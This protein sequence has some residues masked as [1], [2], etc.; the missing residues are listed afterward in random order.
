[1]MTGRIVVGL[2]GSAN[3]SAAARWALREA[4]LRGARLEAVTAFGLFAPVG[5]PDRG[6]LQT[7]RELADACARMQHEQLV[8]L[9]ADDVTVMTRTAPGDAAETLVATAAGA[10]MLV[11]GARGRGGLTGLM[12]GSVTLRCLRR[13]TCPLTVV[14]AY[15][16]EPPAGAPVVVGVKDS[17]SGTAALSLAV[18]EARLRRT[19]VLAVHAVHWPPLGTDLARPTNDQ[20]VEWGTQLL[21]PVV[22]AARDERP[23]VTIQQLVVPGHPAHVLHEQARRAELLVVGSRGH[24]PLAGLLIG[25]VSMHLLTHAQRPITVIA[26]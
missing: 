2:D 20:L 4:R 3:S 9:S 11:V 25:S 12:M 18:E 23:D 8:D 16:E 22:A 7:D 13:A 1:M 21:A 6:H 17:A 14:P 26:E 10:A 5:L 24:G 19:H 15:A